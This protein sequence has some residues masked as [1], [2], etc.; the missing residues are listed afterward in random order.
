MSLNLTSRHEHLLTQHDIFDSDSDDGP[1]RKKQR[2]NSGAPITLTFSD[3]DSDSSNEKSNNLQ[4]EKVTNV[5][6]I[7]LFGSNSS[8]T[9]DSTNSRN[10]D[11]DFKGNSNQ[12]INTQIIQSQNEVIPTE[13]NFDNQPSQKQPSYAFLSLSFQQNILQK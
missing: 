9:S 5:A 2:T 13:Q 4:T 1:P 11:D 10:I 7:D 6:K 3:T 12:N 8:Q